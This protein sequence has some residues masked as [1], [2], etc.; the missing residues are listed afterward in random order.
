MGYETVTGIVAR[1]VDTG[2]A[3]RYLT[4][5]SVEQGRLECYARG[6]RRQGS[7][8]ASQVGLLT[9]GE[10][11]MYVN[12]DRRL[13]T[14]AKSSE[15][16]Y[17][18]RK[19]VEKC[20]YAMHFLDIARD[21]IVEAQAF[22]QA[23]QTLLNTLYALCYKDLQPGF[24]ARAFEMRI[25]AIAG[26]APLTDI[27]SVCGAP[28]GGGKGIGFAVAGGGVVCGSAECRGAASR[29]GRVVA[30]SPGALKA[31]SY[32]SGCGAGQIFQFEISDA[33]AKELS[34][35]VPEYLRHQFGKA[36]DKSDEAE[37]YR[38]F[39][40]EMLDLRRGKNGDAKAI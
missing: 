21:V 39:E 12:K 11:S 32:V 30:V 25:L 16:F 29:V 20:A 37:R 3:D 1:E 40:R 5:L 6:I 15:S 14:S 10:F 22:P 8:L 27:C 36:Y 24:V 31:I 34:S 23:L 4:L 13:L 28:L 35:I 7:K 9:Y 26:F 38:A 33:V 18:I 19:D 2:D 17:G